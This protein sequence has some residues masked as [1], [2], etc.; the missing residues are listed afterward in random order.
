MIQLD[1]VLTL[2]IWYLIKIGLNLKRINGNKFRRIKLK[3]KLKTKKMQRLKIQGINFYPEKQSEN[4]CTL[5][6]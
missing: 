6:H 3:L 2:Q 1:L 5:E 4:G